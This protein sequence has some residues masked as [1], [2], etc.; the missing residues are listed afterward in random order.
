MKIVLGFIGVLIGMGTIF[1][2]VGTG[3]SYALIFINFS[4]PKS[5]VE[6]CFEIGFTCGL[7][8]ALGAGFLIC[9]YFW[10]SYSSGEPE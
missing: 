6:P 9:R 1:L 4:G 10:V 3:V 7:V 8:C 2:L 5:A